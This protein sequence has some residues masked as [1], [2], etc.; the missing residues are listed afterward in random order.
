M[1][2][3]LTLD[4]DL[5]ETARDLTG[6]HQIG[7]LMRS[8]LTAIIQRESSRRLAQLAGAYPELRAPPRRRGDDA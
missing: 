7:A 4:D 6:E 8:A 5:V 1:R 2:A 3:T